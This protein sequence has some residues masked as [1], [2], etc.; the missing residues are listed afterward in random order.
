MKTTSSAVLSLGT[1]YFSNNLRSADEIVK[2]EHLTK[3]LWK[4]FHTVLSVFE[5]VI[6]PTLDEKFS[7]P[8]IIFCLGQPKIISMVGYM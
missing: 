7:E 4:N 2:C 6:T 3:T 8:C 1:V 5:D